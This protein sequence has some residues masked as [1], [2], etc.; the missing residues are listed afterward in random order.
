MSCPPCSH[1]DCPNREPETL[2]VGDYIIARDPT[3]NYWLQN[4]AGE[5]MEV[6]NTDLEK[7]IGDY[8][9]ANF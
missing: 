9:K 8:F 7:L 3:G 6:L 1:P 5:G 4:V 2:T